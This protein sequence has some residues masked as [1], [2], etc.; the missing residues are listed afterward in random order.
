MRRHW[1]YALIGSVV[2]AGIIGAL[3]AGAQRFGPRQAFAEA[4]PHHGFGHRHHGEA[5]PLGH[6]CGEDREAALDAAIAYLERKVEPSAAQAGSFARFAESMRRAGAV[7]AGACAPDMAA[8]EPASAAASLARLEA[9][10]AAGLEA[11][12]EARPAFDA[13]YAVLHEG[14]RKT[15]DDML[16]HR[17][18]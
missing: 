2:G 13:L 4:W 7:M 11:L 8:S 1:R 10:M 16:A 18:G 14:Q 9:M 17:A 15:L 5:G 6:F 3:A 12:R